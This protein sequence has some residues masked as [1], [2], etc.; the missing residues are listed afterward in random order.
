VFHLHALISPRHRQDGYHFPFEH[1]PGPGAFIRCYNN[2]VALV[3]NPGIYRVTIDPVTLPFDTFLYRP[4][5][6][7]LVRGKTGSYQ[8][9]LR[10]K[11]ELAIIFGGAARRPV[12]S[13]NGRT[14]EAFNLFVYPAGF[15]L[16]CF[17]GAG[18]PAFVLPDGFQ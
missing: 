2:P 18:I 8:G 17:D 13:G 6:F 15:L 14:D 1:R 12:G 10:G 4:D 9:G 3:L 7:A 11:H 16:L 5:Q